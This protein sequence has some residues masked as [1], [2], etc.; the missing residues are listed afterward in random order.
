MMQVNYEK[1]K[2]IKVPFENLSAGDT[3]LD[4]SD[5]LCIK[6]TYDNPDECPNCLMWNTTTKSWE[7][8]YEPL[9]RMVRPIETMLTVV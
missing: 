4:Y 6:T 2:E 5:C 7:V 3:Y 1:E 9:D 8:E